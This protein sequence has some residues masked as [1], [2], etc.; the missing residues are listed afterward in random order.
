MTR[1]PKSG[2]GRRW[3]VAELKAIGASWHGDTLADGDGLSGT[4]RLGDGKAVTVHWR[5]AFKRERR[6][7]WHYCGT[8]PVTTLESIRA[9]RDAARDALKRRVDPNEKRE[10]DRLAERERIKAIIE[11]SE[12]RKA[13]DASVESMVR[14]WLRSGVLRKDGNAELTRVFEKDVFPRIGAKAL[15]ATTEEDLGGVLGAVVSRGASRLAVTLYRD[16]RQAFRW[17]DKRQP[18]RRLLMEGNPAELLRIETI[19]GPEYDLSNVRSRVLTAGEIA[20]L[21]NIFA[22]MASDHKHA[23]DKRIAP[24]PVQMTTQHALWIS[25]STAC[26]M[27]ELLM[28][29][30]KH[31]DLDAGTWFIPK[32]NAKGTRGK[33]QD[34]RIFLSRFAR[35]HFTALHRLTGKT[36]W[37]F[38]STDAE[39]H[40]DTKTVSKQVGD[41][42]HRFKNR[43]SLRGRRND[44]SLVLSAGLNGDWTPHDLRRTA[45]TMMQA[46]GIA[47]AVIDRCQNHV[48]A[49]SRVRRHYMIHEYDEEKR[50]AW[51]RLGAALA[52]ILA[53]AA[54]SSGR[55]DVFPPKVIASESVALA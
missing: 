26:R 53:A 3:T 18:W 22:R 55:T 9:A 37:C 7:A 25:L 52:Q 50:E 44:D 30:W 45:A 19:V 35:E 15:R 5:Y 32:E 20:E 41:R 11:D 42:Q 31:V 21:R 48:L 40:V 13:D 49:G 36:A 29:Q 10:A 16:I 27:G 24:R 46:L 12:R 14:A 28:A 43:V 2:H 17:A 38:P 39:T 51:D 6:V 1:Y 54:A 23:A 4:V 34:Q 47:P 33:K 8:W